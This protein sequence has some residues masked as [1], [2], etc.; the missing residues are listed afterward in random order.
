MILETKEV[1]EFHKN[2][3]LQYMTTFAT[4]A[5]MWS[6]LYENIICFPDGS[7]GV[8]QGITQRFWNNGQ[9]N[10]QLEYSENG[11]V[12]QDSCMG[13]RKDGSKIVY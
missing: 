10:W 11:N 4:V 7:Q 13:F 12:I 9:L 2:G 8:R 1:K 3:Q 5:P 6:H